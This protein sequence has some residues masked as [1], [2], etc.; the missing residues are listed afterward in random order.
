MAETYHIYDPFS[1]DVE[2]VSILAYGL[3]DNSRVKLAMCGLKVNLETLLLAHIADATR[4]NVYAK[5]KDAKAGRNRPKS[6]VEELTTTKKPDA[7]TFES[8]K[9]FERAWRELNE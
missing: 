3:R 8:G 7:V 4:T 6:F 1:M 9:D 5:T 2:Y